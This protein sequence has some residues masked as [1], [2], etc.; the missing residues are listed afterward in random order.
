MGVVRQAPYWESG[1]I[2]RFGECDGARAMRL[3]R[4]GGKCGV[5][6][7]VLL[8]LGMATSAASLERRA[9]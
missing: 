2:V 1:L 9:R 8:H 3:V 4:C 7:V 6:R 5:V